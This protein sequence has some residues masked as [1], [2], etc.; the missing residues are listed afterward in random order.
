MPPHQIGPDTP[1]IADVE[2]GEPSD[3]CG[4]NSGL[5]RGYVSLHH[6][7][8]QGDRFRCV[9]VILPLTTCFNACF[10][11][12]THLSALSTQLDWGVCAVWVCFAHRSAMFLSLVRVYRLTVQGAGPI[13]RLIESD[14][15]AGNGTLRS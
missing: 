15:A 14:G 4:S 13:T 1:K 10:H 7:T 11:I 8:E 5:K 3:P 12:A 2:L 9:K 6:G